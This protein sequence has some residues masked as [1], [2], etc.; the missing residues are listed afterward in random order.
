[1]Q[2]DFA[3]LCQAATACEGFLNILGGGLNAINLVQFPGA[4]TA[5]V[6]MNFWCDYNDFRTPHHVEVR[7]IDEDGRAMPDIQVPGMEI[8]GD[9]DAMEQNAHLHYSVQSVINLAGVAI[10][11]PGRYAID[12]LL[13]RVPVKRIPFLV[14]QVEPLQSA[15]ES[16]SPTMPRI[17]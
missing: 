17:L 12:I 6:A 4:V 8:T 1:M 9:Q 13:D 3:V 2:L 5:T 10:H 15:P 14:Q 7:F 16:P 11:R